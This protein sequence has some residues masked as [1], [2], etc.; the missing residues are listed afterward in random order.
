MG[1]DEGIVVVKQITDEKKWCLA[2]EDIKRRFQG[3]D[4][5]KEYPTD[6]EKANMVN[7]S[8]GGARMFDDEI[9]AKAW[10]ILEPINFSEQGMAFHYYWQYF[11]SGLRGES[12]DKDAIIEELDVE[13]VKLWKKLADSKKEEGSM[14]L[15]YQMDIERV[16]LA[17]DHLKSLSPADIELLSKA[18]AISPPCLFEF[19]IGEHPRLP[20]FGRHFKS[21]SSK[22]LRGSDKVIA[23][24]YKI[25]HRHFPEHVFHWSELRGEWDHR[26]HLDLSDR[27]FKSAPGES[28]R[29]AEFYRKLEEQFDNFK[30][31]GTPEEFRMAR[32]AFA[33]IQ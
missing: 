6:D 27:F 29:R 9:N 12:L 10:E 26:Y 5:F 19:C 33:G 24:I 4:Y 14:E 20:V 32:K 1:I 13:K 11:G 25:L 17:L 23:A 7:I 22:I 18:P 15:Y 28:E 2:M 21:C 30:Q 8:R 3:E 31:A 16:D